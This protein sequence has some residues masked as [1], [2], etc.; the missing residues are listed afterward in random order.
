MHSYNRFY[1]FSLHSLHKYIYIFDFRQK[2]LVQFVQSVF[3]MF[4]VKTY[5]KSE[6][7]WLM[8]PDMRDPSAAQD[9]LLRWIKKD[10]RFHK[11]LLRLANTKD[12][13]NYSKEQIQL[14][15]D[16]FGEPG[17]YDDY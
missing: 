11:R 13:N 2:I 8:F 3:N 9:K 1:V 15:I 5:G 12:D 7:A 16:K 4:K 10:P 17:E 14:I 6:F